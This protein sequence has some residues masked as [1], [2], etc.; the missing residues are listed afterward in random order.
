M[1]KRRDGPHA[2]LHDDAPLGLVLAVQK[3]HDHLRRHPG[4][5]YLDVELLAARAAVRSAVVQV[6][7]EILVCTECANVITIVVHVLT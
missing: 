1:H 4:L 5:G 2:Y 3:L 7:A 6:V